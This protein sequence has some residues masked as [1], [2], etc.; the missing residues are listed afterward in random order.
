MPEYLIEKQ[1]LDGLADSIRAKTETTAAMT[2]EEMIEN[3]DNITTLN[4]GTADATATAE[5][6]VSG[7]TAYVNGAKVTGTASLGG[8]GGGTRFGNG[9]G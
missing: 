5:D 1:T 8:G 3:I 6:I 9:V 2:P 4:E 7:K